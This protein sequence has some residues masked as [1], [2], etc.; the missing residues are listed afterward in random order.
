MFKIGLFTS[1]EW[2]TYEFLI[3]FFAVF[4]CFS[5]SQIDNLLFTKN[6]CRCEGIFL[7]IFIRK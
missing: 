6:S 4:I 1:D 3:I 5:Y 7:L 2:V